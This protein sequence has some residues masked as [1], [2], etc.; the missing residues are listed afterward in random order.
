MLN[1]AKVCGPGSRVVEGGENGANNKALHSVAIDVSLCYSPL[2]I[3]ILAL[4]PSLF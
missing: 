1:L 2:F 3:S 4:F